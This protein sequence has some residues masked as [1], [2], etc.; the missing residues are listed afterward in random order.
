VI[1]VDYVAFVAISFS[2]GTTWGVLA[3]LVLGPIMAIPELI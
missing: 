2:A 3:L 1:A